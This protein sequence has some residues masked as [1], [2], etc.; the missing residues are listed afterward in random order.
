MNEDLL[1]WYKIFRVV[2]L[3]AVLYA[4]VW[5]LYFTPAGKRLEEPAK[6]M[7]EEDDV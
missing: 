3:V 7:L 5:Y 2:L 4:I 1:I 6:R